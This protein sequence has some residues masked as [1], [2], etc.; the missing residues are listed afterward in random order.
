MEGITNE[1]LI[2]QLQGLKN[3]YGWR[4]ICQQ[5]MTDRDNAMQCF[6][7]KKAKENFEYLQATVHQ[8]D[9]FLM[10]PDKII[11]LHLPNELEQQDIA[12]KAAELKSY[13][14]PVKSNFEKTVEKRIDDS[15]MKESFDP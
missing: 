9:T 7:S 8:I 12:R 1:E 2:S 10:Y 14:N 5:L 15:H 13:I 11:S 3:S 6:L 4:I